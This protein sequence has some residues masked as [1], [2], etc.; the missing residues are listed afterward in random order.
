MLNS[1]CG[2][3]IPTYKKKKEQY[4][5]TLVPG[6]EPDLRQHMDTYRANQMGIHGCTI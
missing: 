5:R 3:K 4:S 2:L 1:L 6:I